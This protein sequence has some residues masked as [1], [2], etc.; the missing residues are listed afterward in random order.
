[1]MAPGILNAMVRH[2]WLYL[3]YWWNEIDFSSA[4]ITFDRL[5]QFC[6]SHI[7]PFSADNLTKLEFKG[8]MYSPNL[9]GQNILKFSSTCASKKFNSWTADFYPIYGDCHAEKIWMLQCGCIHL[10]YFWI[11]SNKTLTIFVIFYIGDSLGI[12][13]PLRA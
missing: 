1:M 12:K 9:S 10:L 6:F 8:F 13:S 11:V 7:T 2:L 5:Y 4:M 3:R